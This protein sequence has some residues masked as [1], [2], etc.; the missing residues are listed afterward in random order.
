MDV[1]IV[2]RMRCIHV[3]LCAMFLAA[4]LAL[5]GIVVFENEMRLEWHDAVREMQRFLQDLQDRSEKR[6]FRFGPHEAEGA[7]GACLKIKDDNH[8]LVEWLAYH[9]FVMPLRHLIVLVDDKSATSPIPVLDRWKNYMTIQIVDWDFRGVRPAG[10][11]NISAVLEHRGPHHKFLENCLRSYKRLGWDSWVMLIDTDEMLSINPQARRPN[12]KVSRKDVPPT[13]EAGSV[14][15]FLKQEMHR[16][17]RQQDINASNPFPECMLVFRSQICDIDDS[18]NSSASFVPDGF[19][20]S[21]FLTMRWLDL[22]GD[23]KPKD[24]V[25]VGAVEA[26]YFEELD[27]AKKGTIHSVLP[28]RCTERPQRQQDSLFV[29]YHYDGNVEQRN[30]RD[31]VRG[32]YGNRQG[33]TKP[34]TTGCAR[35]AGSYLRPWLRGFVEMVGVTEAKRLL[36]GVG[37]CKGWPPYSESSTAIPTVAA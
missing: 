4:L 6:R 29:V 21:D 22:G 3:G 20:A 5:T 12:Y 27:L 15:K 14:M 13:S 19:R 35:Q 9:W 1:S 30:F 17:E 32:A 23:R 16:H 10:M 37:S 26:E 18:R 2:P 34:Q 11:P 28:G 33:G 7:W 31:D 24:I 25:N 8:W 36:E